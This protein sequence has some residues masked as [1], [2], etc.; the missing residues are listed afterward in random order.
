MRIKDVI[1]EAIS[2]TQYEQT[3]I[4][5]LNDAI[6][7]S[8]GYL[9]LYRLPDDLAATLVDENA[10]DFDVR[11]YIENGL[12]R[13]LKETIPI[14]LKNNLREALGGDIVTS[15]YVEPTKNS[16][17]FVSNRSI[18]LDLKPVKRIASNAMHTLMDILYDNYDTNERVNGFYK[19]TKEIGN[20]DKFFW[21]EI[22]YETNKLVQEYT[23]T[24]L[25]ELVHVIQHQAQHQQGRR[26]RDFEY[27]SY[28]DTHKGEFRDLVSAP[29]E[30]DDRYFNLYLSSPQEI[31][32]FAHEAAL[33]L[34]RDYGFNEIDSA[35][36][37]YNVEASDIVS[38]VNQIT[39]QRFKEPK[40][41]QE[42]LVKQ[43]Y[44]KLVYQEVQRYIQ[45]RIA[46]FKKKNP[47]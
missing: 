9:A 44:I 32:A 16:S 23:S 46:S 39:G 26:H 30:K 36:G 7:D 40:T 38:Y 5:A 37:F 25:H 2:V 17:A 34:I 24:I 1:D 29:H 3:V 15:I 45:Y 18:T 27:R 4:D 22:Y 33:R 19:A 10:S 47:V 12:V 21:R 8:I 14:R 28:L 35:E 11:E 43:R 13:F 31:A 42:Q 6:R 41:R 20:G